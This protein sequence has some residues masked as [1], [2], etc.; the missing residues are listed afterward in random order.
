[1]SSD[2]ARPAVQSEREA[3]LDAAGLAGLRVLTLVDENT[4]AGIQ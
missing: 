1:M 3:L 4:A 2:V